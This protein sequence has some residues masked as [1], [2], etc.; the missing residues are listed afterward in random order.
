MAWAPH[1]RNEPFTR[2]R[3]DS[4]EEGISKPEGRQECCAHAAVC[5]ARLGSC[6]NLSLKSAIYR[7]EAAIAPSK[8]H[9]KLLLNVGVTIFKFSFEGRNSIF[10]LE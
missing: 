6:K 9:E 1:P 10:T 2:A 8:P 7:P 5:D 3:H 4:G